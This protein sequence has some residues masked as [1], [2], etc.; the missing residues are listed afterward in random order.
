[1]RTKPDRG[2]HND[3]M[4]Q[5]PLFALPGES[6]PMQQDGGGRSDQRRVHKANTI[7][8]AP[9][10]K[11]AQSELFSEQVSLCRIRP[12]LNEWRYY[13]L[14]V[15]PDLFGRALLV[16]HYGRIGTVG[17]RKLE[18]FPD[19]GAAVNMLARLHR[20]KLRRGYGAW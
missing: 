18:P 5:P 7:E 15:W 4:V 1:M 11:P 13:R 19:A 10:E 16:R 14:E 17:R 8:L 2:A 3:T 12:D 6:M 9:P 20:A